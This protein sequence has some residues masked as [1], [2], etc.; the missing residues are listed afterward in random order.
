M[1]IEAL[2]PLKCSSRGLEAA[3]MSNT[4]Q[5]RVAGRDLGHPIVPQNYSDIKST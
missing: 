2:T 3:E 1:R 5:N 4:V